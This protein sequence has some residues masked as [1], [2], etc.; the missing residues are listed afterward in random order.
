MNFMYK[1]AQFF[2]G[3]NGVDK[4]CYF[5]IIIY[6]LLCF[7]NI[8][9]RS[10]IVTI[11]SLV[12]AGFAIYRVLSR[13]ITQRQKEARAFDSILNRIKYFFSILRQRF[14]QR[15]TYC[16]HSCPHCKA[17]LRLPRKKGKHI[18]C[19]PRCKKDFSMRVWF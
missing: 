8:F 9:A 3:R 17:N 19:C 15:K 12:I 4:L 1:V 14:V 18:V 10:F 16:F 2:Q 11:I 13:N 5:L 6:S 7:V